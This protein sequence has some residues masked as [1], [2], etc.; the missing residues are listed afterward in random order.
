MAG[1]SI[2]EGDEAKL[3]EMG[4]KDSKLLTP[5]KRED[6]FEKI[7]DS[8]EN[9]EI[10]M[11]MPD[12]IDAALNSDESNLNWLEADTSIIIIKKLKPNKGIIDSPSN[13]VKAYKSYLIERLK[14]MQKL[15]ELIV[16]HKA[17]VNHAPCAAASILAKVT[18]DR[19]IEKLKKSVKIDFGS[20]YMTDPKTVEFL[21]RYYN[22]HPDLFRKSWKPYQ[23]VV[24]KK[25]QK[26]MSEWL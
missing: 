3:W 12:V 11:L 21:E 9:Y 10:V 18:R 26:G 22:K 19:E 13:N 5:K 17:D 20:G 14:E 1:V 15:P 23:K 2:N 25:L 16:E 24:G 7:K 4:V 8:V 6:L